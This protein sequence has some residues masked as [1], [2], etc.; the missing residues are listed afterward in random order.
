[1]FEQKINGFKGILKNGFLRIHH[2]LIK[3]KSV[4]V[5]RGSTDKWWNNVKREDLQNN[6]WKR[7]FWVSKECFFETLDKVKLWLDPKPNCP[8]YRFFSAEKKLAITLYYLKDT[9]SL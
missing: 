7:N 3:P 5:A 1:M 4:W 2:L 6:W 9:G 8:S